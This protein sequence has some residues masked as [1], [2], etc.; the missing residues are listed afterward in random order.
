MVTDITRNGSGTT[1]SVFSISFVLPAWKTEANS[2]FTAFSMGRTQEIVY[3]LDKMA[4]AR[5]LPD[6][7]VYVEWPL[8]VDATDVFI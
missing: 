8:A 1:K 5:I 7:P 3:M 6:I 2:S 4:T